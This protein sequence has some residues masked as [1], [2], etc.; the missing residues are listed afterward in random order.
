MIALASAKADSKSAS[1]RGLTGSRAYSRINGTACLRIDHVHP[2]A[3]PAAQRGEQTDPCRGV[4][5][6]RADSPLTPSPVPNVLF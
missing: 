3:R 6:M 2:P 5:L 4:L 1:S